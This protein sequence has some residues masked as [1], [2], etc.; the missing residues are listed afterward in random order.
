MTLPIDRHWKNLSWIFSVEIF[1]GV[2]LALISNIA[3]LPVFLTHLG[4]SNTTVGALP[5]LFLIATGIPGIFAA[6]FTGRMVYR[7]RFVIVAHALTA[8]PWLL[9]A[10]WFVAGPRISP[11]VD[12]AVL[13][14]GWGL[15]WLW[16]GLLIPIWINFI[17]KVTRPEL[18]ARSFGII[19]FFQTMMS[20][21]G[22][23]VASKI[24]GGGAPFPANYGI[25]FAITGAAMAIGAIF[26]APVVEEAGAVSEEVDP[27]RGIVRHTREIL[28]DRGGIRTYLSIYMLAAGWPVL[29]AF[30]P[31]WAEKRFALEAKDSAIYTA[32]CMAGNM[33]G[34]LLSGAV[35][36]RY[37]Y[38]KVAVIATVAFSVGLA[39]AILGDSR[40]WYYV[41]AFALG[42]YIVSDRLAMYNLSMAFSPHEDNTSYLA[43]VPALCTP[44]LVVAAALCGPLIDAHGFV[45]V[46]AGSLALGLVAVYLAVFRL[47]EPRY[48]LAGKRRP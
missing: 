24:I 26:F 17:G 18:R 40:V 8:I 9:T 23:W 13:L 27:L 29:T 7:K 10:A 39:T 1:W 4:A 5:V 31:I 43:L 2:G 15:S 46:A 34:S 48:S 21:V 38:A 25:G 47:P 22:G 45:P 35:G 6:H 20:M 36:D 42:V 41:T 37:G 14:A 44:V 11:A 3:I 19:F 12:I 30:Y 32:V 33:V 16:M 28:T